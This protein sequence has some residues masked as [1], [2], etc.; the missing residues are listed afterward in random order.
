MVEAYNNDE[1]ENTD[2]TDMS[3]EGA[4]AASEG[5]KMPED[6]ELKAEAETEAPSDEQDMDSDQ[7]PGDS[8]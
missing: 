3:D 2:K 8:M 7:D 1:N 4:L 5:K 6:D